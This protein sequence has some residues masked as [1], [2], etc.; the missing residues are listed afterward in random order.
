MDP[1]EGPVLMGLI[2]D[3][4][5]WFND[6][7]HW[8]GANGIPTRMMQHLQY[9]I[10]AIVAAIVIAVPLA[11]WLGH[12]RRF[13]ATA[14]NLSNVGRAVPSFAILVIGTQI[15]GLRELPVIGSLTTF[16]ALVALAVP[17]LVTNSYVAVAEIDD[18]VRDSA[19]GMGLTEF[20][21]L[22]WVE[23]PLSVPLLM[24]GIRT[25]SVQVVAT[26]TIAAFVG[27]GGLGRYIIDG[28]VLPNPPDRN[29]Q[30]FAGAV[31]V[32]VLSLL[33]E[34]LLGLA[35]RVLTPEGLRTQL[36]PTTSIA[37]TAAV[38]IAH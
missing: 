3:V 24:A 8:R 32:A 29:V 14:S 25:A 4:F 1:H 12:R 36:A 37:A 26:A 34:L 23:L 20:Q 17:P 27:V 11:V 21:Q 13:G 5:S 31:L 38:P 6:P 33:T 10:S 30:I 19:R 35:Q 7:S 9:S 28:R 16:I 22:R 18:E 15:F 2:G